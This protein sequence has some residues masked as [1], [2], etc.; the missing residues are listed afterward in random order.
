MVEEMLSI[1]IPTVT[2]SMLRSSVIN[3]FLLGFDCQN[4]AHGGTAD[5]QP[6]GDLGFADTGSVRLTHLVGMDSSC[7][8]PTLPFCRAW[9]QAGTHPFLQ[10][11]I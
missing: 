11:A 4:P 10:K 2:R 9:A 5:L 3:S 1:V 6:A 7:D 8:G